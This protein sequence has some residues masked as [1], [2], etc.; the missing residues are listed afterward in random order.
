MKIEIGESLGYSYLRN[1]KRCWLVQ[2]NWKPSE[3]WVKQLTGDELEHEFQQIRDRVDPEGNV[4]KGTKNSRQ[5]LK[6]AE[7]D[8]VGFD[9]DG[10]IHAMDVAFHEAGLNYLGGAYKRVLKK[11]LRTKLVLDAYHPAGAVRNVYFV[12]P[13]VHRGAQQPLEEVFGRLQEVYPSVNWHL[14]TNEIF[15]N[16]ML[17]PTLEKAESVSDTAELFVRS[18]KLLSLADSGSAIRHRRTSVLDESS[19]N[20]GQTV[21]KTN[22]TASPTLQDMAQGLMRT[23]LEDHHSLLSESDRFNLMNADYCQEHLDLHL[24]GFPLL[25]HKQEGRSISG[26]DRYYE[27]V[28]AAQFL[29]SNNWWKRHHNHNAASLLRL[30]DGLIDKNTDNA[31]M[32][33]LNAHRAELLDYLDQA[34]S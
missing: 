28:Y 15:T 11:L 24:G 16:E 3:H 7:I 32:S 23:L 6:Q 8:V 27:K 2:T 34:I 13:K 12:S 31:G 17:E 26:H 20:A 30:V 19:A 5:F 21:S 33:A 9:Q 25:R 4:F 14:L 1:V 29:V 18:A 22:S 10:A